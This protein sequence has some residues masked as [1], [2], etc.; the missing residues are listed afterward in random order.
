MTQFKTEAVR[1]CRV[2]DRSISQVAKDVDLTEIAMR[3]RVHRTDVS[4]GKG[5]AGALASDERAECA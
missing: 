3:E 2:G 1:L 4:A 5:P